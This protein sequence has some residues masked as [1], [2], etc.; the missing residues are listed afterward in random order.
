MIPLKEEGKEIVAAD[1]Q[2]G[3]DQVFVLANDGKEP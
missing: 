3:T 1:I 2:R